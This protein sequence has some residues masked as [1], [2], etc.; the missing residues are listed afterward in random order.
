M[1]AQE[2]FQELLR[3]CEK[4]QDGVE[5]E[6]LK[7]KTNLLIELRDEHGNL[8]DRREIHNLICTVGKQELLKASTAKYVNQFSYMVIGTG[9]GAANIAD[10]YATFTSPTYS[11][12]ITP[13]NPDANTL[14]FQYTYAAGT[15]TGAITESGLLD[16][17][18]TGKL[19]CR[20]TFS[21]INKAAADS[22]QMT[23]QIT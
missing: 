3:L 21:A 16:S 10:T 15:G 7:L 19:L 20:Q 17:N 8:K 9:T 22:L 13:T 23:W 2:L 14:Q 1:T 11:T 12:V 18:T 5:S 4:V 6:V